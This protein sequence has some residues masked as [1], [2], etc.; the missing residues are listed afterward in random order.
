MKKVIL[1]SGK[2]RSGKNQYAEFLKRDFESKGLKVKEDLYAKDLKDYSVEDFSMLGSVLKHKVE[3]IKSE[4]GVFFDFHDKASISAQDSINKKLDELIFTPSNFYEDKTDITRALL[5]LYGTNIARNRFHDHFWIERMA[6]RLNEDTEH[7]VIIVTD[8][9]FP[10]EI[11]DIQE[12][13]KDCRIVPIRIERDFDRNDVSKEHASE[14]ALDEY[15]FFEW[16]IDNNG[17]LEELEQASDTV[18]N[19]ILDLE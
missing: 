6:K 4:L 19:Y 17:T 5:Q 14:T 9:R 7:D 18:T 3:A 2:M 10:N 16:I 11:E 15:K 1:L 8:V 12:Y 13:V